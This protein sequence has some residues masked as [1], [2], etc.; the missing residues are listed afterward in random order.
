MQILSFKA[1]LE[2]TCD[3]SSHDVKVKTR[4]YELLE[5]RGHSCRSDGATEASREGMCRDIS[6]LQRALN[7]TVRWIML[8]LYSRV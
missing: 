7:L 3:Y 6:L 2:G 8:F 5:F 1:S 4:L